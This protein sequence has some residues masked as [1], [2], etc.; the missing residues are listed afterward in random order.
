LQGHGSLRLWTEGNS[1][2]LTLLVC[3]RAGLMLAVLQWACLATA[4]LLHTLQAAFAHLHIHQLTAALVSKTST[5]NWPYQCSKNLVLVASH[6]VHLHVHWL[7]HT[8]QISYTDV[9]SM[10]KLTSAAARPEY[11]LHCWQS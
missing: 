9:C 6:F 7:I 10:V 4:A 8:V 1:R 3:C 5:L 2:N 11:L